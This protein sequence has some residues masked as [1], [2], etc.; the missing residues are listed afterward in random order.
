MYIKKGGPL[1][2]LLFGESQ[3]SEWSQWYKVPCAKCMLSIAYSNK[4]IYNNSLADRFRSISLTIPTP[5]LGIAVHC[6]NTACALTE[7]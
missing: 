6:T 2:W 4:W 1:L 7:S 5:K 3:C